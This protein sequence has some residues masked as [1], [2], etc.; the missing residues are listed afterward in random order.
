MVKLKDLI[1]EAKV[2]ITRQALEHYLYFIVNALRGALEKSDNF[3]RAHR[4][5][6]DRIA[7]EM[8]LKHGPKQGGIIYRGIIL[9]DHEV[10]NGKVL[11]APEI[12]FVSFSEDKNIAI[13]FGDIENPSWEHGKLRYPTKKG[14]LITAKYQ[15]DH[16]LYH[17]SWLKSA[18]LMNIFQQAFGNDV[19]YTAQQ[20]EVIIKPRPYYR[21]EPVAPG[22]SGGIE[23]DK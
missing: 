7:E 13:A 1:M 18:N 12:T 2:P 6:I 16:V 17:W 9:D 21:V 10:K 11:H 23:V 5:D 19:K 4:G 15:P 3:Y 22:T 14:Y 20:K 8:V